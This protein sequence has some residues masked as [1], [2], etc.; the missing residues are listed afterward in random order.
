[1]D[2]WISVKDKLPDEYDFVLVIAYNNGTGEPKPISIARIDDDSEWDFCNRDAC[3]SC[4]GAWMDIEYI[5]HVDDITHWM[6]LP[7]IDSIEVKDE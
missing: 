6:P 2:S 5:M 4:Y 7:S 1:M 3:M